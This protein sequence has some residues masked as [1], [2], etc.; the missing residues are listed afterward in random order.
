MA[1]LFNIFKAF[2]YCLL[3]AA[4]FAIATHYGLPAYLSIAIPLGIIAAIANSKR[5][6]PDVWVSDEVYVVIHTYRK[7]EECDNRVDCQFQFA[8][9]WS[10]A[11]EILRNEADKH[12]M[13]LRKPIACDNSFG[14]V[15][16]KDDNGNIW[17]LQIAK[18]SIRRSE[19]KEF[20]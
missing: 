4:L 8:K 10:E 16:F 18:Q 3:F 19:F 20:K 13:Q 17:S 14:Y 5:T 12:I 1:F 6:L 11:R 2:L 9:T 15:K 7:A